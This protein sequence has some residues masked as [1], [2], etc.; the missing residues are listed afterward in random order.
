MVV[1]GYSKSL[2]HIKVLGNKV[3]IESSQGYSLD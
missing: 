3:K 2:L 1:A